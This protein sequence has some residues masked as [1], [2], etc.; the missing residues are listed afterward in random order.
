VSAPCPLDDHVWGPEELHEGHGGP[1][2]GYFWAVRCLS[3]RSGYAFP[4]SGGE[5]GYELLWA[6]PEAAGRKA[7]PEDDEEEA[8]G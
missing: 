7:E 5:G 1:L 2:D 6:A 4:A 8:V 3:C